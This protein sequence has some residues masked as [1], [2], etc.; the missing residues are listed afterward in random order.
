MMELWK[1]IPGYEGFYEVSN[2]GRIKSLHLKPKILNPKA[3]SNRYKRVSL[4]VGGVKKQYSVHRLVMLAFVGDSDLQVNH[5][6]GNKDNNEL[7]NL[8]YCTSKENISHAWETGI[9]A[10][11][12]QRYGKEIIEEYEKGT[13]LSEVSKKFKI[14][15]RNLKS[16]LIKNGIEIRDQRVYMIKNP[17]SV[18]IKLFNE[19]KPVN[20]IAEELS[21]SISTV[22]N[23][24][25]NLEKRNLINKSNVYKRSPR[26]SV[27]IKKTLIDYAN[28][29]PKVKN[30][31][32]SKRFGI[33]EQS[34][35]RILKDE[36]LN[37]MLKG[38]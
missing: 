19:E 3:M 31:D 34:V 33:S 6:D 2:F 9:R 5:I 24:R 28:K 1:D 4:S 32:L 25:K 17:D 27:E 22:I 36:R 12:T 10:S 35:G 38:R 15:T 11:S 29:N 14:D 8:E 30:V 21:V 18:Y 37:K 26:I 16:H 7:S 23:R 13:P 20:E